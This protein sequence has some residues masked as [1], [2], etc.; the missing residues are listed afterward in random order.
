[1]QDSMES[2]PS[3]DAVR[4][5]KAKLGPSNRPGAMLATISITMA[6]ILWMIPYITNEVTGPLAQ[7]LGGVPYGII[8]HAL[9]D[10]SPEPNTHQ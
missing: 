2:A 1:M 3:M 7:G 8:T 9:S 10:H 4:V 5:V 6:D